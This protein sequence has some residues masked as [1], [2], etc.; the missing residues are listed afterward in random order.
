MLQTATGVELVTTG[1]AN[2]TTGDIPAVLAS[3]APEIVWTIPGPHQVAG[4]YVGPSGVAEFFGK[5]AAG[6][7]RLELTVERYV[8]SGDDEVIAI[9]HHDGSG[10][11]G[12][13]ENLGFVHIWQLRDGLV[14]AFREY[15]DTEALGRALGQ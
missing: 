11:G 2:F 1:Y 12:T 14:T 13:F 15:T 7:S 4:R 6:Y 9:G 8:S 10:P 3:F 5:L